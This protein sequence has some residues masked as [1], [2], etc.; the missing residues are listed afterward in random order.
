[1][2]FFKND[3]DS[4]EAAAQKCSLKFRKINRKA[5]V[6]NSIFL[7]KLQDENFS[8]GLSDKTSPFTVFDIPVQRNIS[9]N[10]K[11]IQ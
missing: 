9:K 6:P 1:M 4:P 11:N 5:P 2:Y 8:V 10:R 7:I 3:F